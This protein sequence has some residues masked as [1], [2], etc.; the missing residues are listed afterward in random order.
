MVIPVA[1]KVWQPIWVA[2]P[3][4][5]G[6][7]IDHLERPPAHAS[8]APR[9]R[10]S[11]RAPPGKRALLVLA[12]PGRLDVGVKVRLERVVHRHL[13]VLAALLVQP[14]P[15]ALALGEVVLDPHPERRADPRKAVDQDA[16]QR[17]IAQPDQAVGG[18]ALEELARLFR[19]RGS[20]CGRG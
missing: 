6:P 16:D 8:D 4:G 17:P 7:P 5:F 12:D 1:R 2:I 14:E 3:A 10:H 19:A 9:A 18:D 15:P 11:W 20:A 13:V